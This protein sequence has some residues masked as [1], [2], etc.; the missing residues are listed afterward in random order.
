MIQTAISSCEVLRRMLQLEVWRRRQP[1]EL[2]AARLTAIH[3]LVGQALL[4]VPYYRRIA[5]DSA[6]DAWISGGLDEFRSMPQT[7]KEAVKAHFPDGMVA[8]GLDWSQLY[9]MQTSGTTDRIML[10]QNEER[11]NWD[12]AADLLLK[13][14]DNGF[15]NGSKTLSMPP[16]ACYEHCGADGRMVTY[17]VGENVRE[18]WRARGAERR[19]AARSLRNSILAEYVWRERRLPSL[20]VD[21]TA[22][23]E[24]FLEEYCRQI[25][26]WSPLVISGL[27]MGLYVVALFALKRGLEFPTVRIVRPNGGKFSRVMADTVARAFG[28]TLRENYGSAELNSMAMDC[29]R[30]REQHLFEGVFYLEVLR[31]GEPVKPGELGEIVVTDLRNCVTPLIRYQVGDVGRLMEGP[32]ACGF[33]GTRFVVDGR[34]QETVVTPDGHAVSGMELVDLFLLRPEIDHVRFL[35]EADDVFLAE[36]VPAPGH[37]LPAADEMEASLSELLRYPARLR[38]RKVRRVAPERNGKYRLVLSTSHDRFHLQSQN[39]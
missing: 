21:G 17:S 15:L 38:M 28:A 33:E 5:A 18:W 23:S 36:V 16:D 6:R 32:C 19:K 8:E 3:E 4:R 34:M 30:S 29:R 24:D 2:E 25:R 26:D 1:E 14:R 27:P 10:F 20:G 31:C 11:R 7:T 9:S 35:Q 39:V 13:L 22:A 12:R 37:E